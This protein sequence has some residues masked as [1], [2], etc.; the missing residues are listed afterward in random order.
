[1]Q[2][3]KETA[4]KDT[5]A[6]QAAISKALREQG[7]ADEMMKE[8]KGKPKE[9][10]VAREARE[11]ADAALVAAEAAAAKAK[12]DT[13]RAAEAERSETGAPYLAGLNIPT[14]GATVDAW[15]LYQEK[16]KKVRGRICSKFYF[17]VGQ[18]SE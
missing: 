5:S 13:E 8:A 15:T 12:E 16:I 3:A 11:A 2:D 4:K 14:S 18:P 10:A 6:S 1:M 7:E 17:S 9:E